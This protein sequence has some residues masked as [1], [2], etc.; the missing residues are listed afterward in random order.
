MGVEINIEMITG[1]FF[2]NNKKECL[3]KHIGFIYKFSE[4]WIKD[5]KK[6]S[7]MLSEEQYNNLYEIYNEINKDR[8]FYEN[9]RRF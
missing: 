3:K 4:E 2:I 1:Q 8:I 9:L 6:W 7:K 5:K